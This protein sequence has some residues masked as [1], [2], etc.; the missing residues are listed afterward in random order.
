MTW[1]ALCPLEER[2]YRGAGR[3]RRRSRGDGV[4]VV[5]RSRPSCLRGG[6]CPG[7]D[8]LFRGSDA[9]VLRIF[10]LAPLV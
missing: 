5:E 2:V 3:S 6:S 1:A 7:L 9:V 4:L 8:S 10:A